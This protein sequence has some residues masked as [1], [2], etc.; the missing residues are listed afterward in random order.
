M[1]NLIQRR[2][3]SL[4]GWSLSMPVHRR[5]DLDCPCA[6]LL[7]YVILKPC[8]RAKGSRDAKGRSCPRPQR[9]MALLASRIGQYSQW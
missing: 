4:R 2:G 5:G 8:C 6:Y 7:G 9:D 1:F 3:R